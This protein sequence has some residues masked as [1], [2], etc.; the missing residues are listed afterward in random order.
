MALIGQVASILN[1]SQSSLKR[2]EAAG[3]IPKPP[4]RPTGLREYSEEHIKAIEKFLAE[5]R[6]QS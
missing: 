5:K 3:V 6:K 2:W 4:R 1:V